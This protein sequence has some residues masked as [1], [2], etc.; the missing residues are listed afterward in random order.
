MTRDTHEDDREDAVHND[1]TMVAADKAALE[2]LRRMWQDRDPVPPDLADRIWFVLS[3]ENLEAELM[4]LS[5]SYDAEP[6]GA[7]GEERARNVTF[8][9]DSLSVMVTISEDAPRVRLDGWIGDGGGLTVALREMP[10]GGSATH[11]L[12][13]TADEDGRF[14]FFDLGHGL[15]QLVFQPTRGAR[16]SLG[17]PVVTPAVQI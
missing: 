3:M 6:A 1:A 15:I 10:N 16:L 9:S 14:A 5:A 7:R 17:Q 8:T 13:T 11:E 4:M 2:T 12:S